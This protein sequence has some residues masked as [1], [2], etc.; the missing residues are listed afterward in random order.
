MQLSSLSYV[1]STTTLFSLNYWFQNDATNCPT[2]AALNNGQINCITDSV[3]TGRGVSYAYDSLRRI[4]SAVTNGSTNYPKWGLSWSYDQYGNRTAQSVTAGSAPSSSLIF[5]VTKNRPNGYTFD[6]SGNLTVEAVGSTNNNYSYDAENRMKGVSGGANATYSYDGSDLRI[7]KVVTGGTTTVYVFVGDQDI[8]EYDN[9]AAV[10]SPTREYIYSGGTLVSTISSGTTKYHHSDHLSVRLTTDSNGNVVGQQGHFPFGENW[11]SASTTTKFIFTSYE[12]DSE[13]GLEYALARYYDTRMGRFCS[14][15]PLEGWPG[16]PQSWN[17]Y[18]YGRN[19]PVNVIDPTGKGW[20]MSL[21]QGILLGLAEIFS[22]GTATPFIAAAEAGGPSSQLLLS[23]LFGI[24]QG[25][26]R[27][28]NQPMGGMQQN[29]KQSQTP[30]GY[31]PCP[32]VLFRIKAPDPRQA[33]TKGGAAGVHNVKAPGNVAYN[34]DDV[35][36]STSDAQALDR[37]NAPILFKPDWS[38]GQIPNSEGGYSK[39]APKRGMPRVPKGLPVSQ[40]ATLKESWPRK[41]GQWLKWRFGSLTAYNGR[42]KESR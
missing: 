3:D 41:T 39:P 28:G 40:D 21:L 13:T 22:G 18:A 27:I 31:H 9:G 2:G 33:T 14:P 24:G 17:R 19:D 38:T 4:S 16:D 29:L 5:D 37:S 32:P 6:N 11:Y 42:E 26:D 12:H 23:I 36:L 7:K 1:K 34:P 10:N 35:G 25:M 20:L 30:K 8:A 15:D